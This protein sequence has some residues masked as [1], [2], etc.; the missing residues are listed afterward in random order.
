MK[1]RGIKKIPGRSW[2]LIDGTMHYFC[3]H[4]KNHP[5]LLQI[6]NFGKIVTKKLKQQDYKPDIS[7]V[8]K[9]ISNQSKE[10]ELC[11][12]S[13]RYALHL[14]LLKIPAPQPIIIHKNLRVCG[15]CHSY[16]KYLSKLFQ[17]EIRLKDTA[18]WHIFKDGQ[19]NCNDN[20]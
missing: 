11:E 7:W 14:G 15:D 17:R 2:I 8:S 19:C 20:Y 10:I 4:E 5:N 9:D 3:A 6:K 16:T 1:E 12:H 18:V 13:E